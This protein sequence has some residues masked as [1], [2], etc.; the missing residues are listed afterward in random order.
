VPVGLVAWV[1]AMVFH[2][3][4]VPDVIG[5]L[6]GLATLTAAS[7]ALV[8]RGLVD[9]VDRWSRGRVAN[10]LPG[11][12]S[13]PSVLVLVFTTL[14]RAAAILS[15]PHTQWAWVFI[16]TAVVGR[17]AAIFLQG[18]GDPIA[19]D[20]SAR[21][22]VAVPAPAWL[23]AAISGAVVVL[24]VVALGKIGIVAMALAAVAVFAVGLATQRRD[25][26][27]SPGVVATAA[28]IGELLVLL[29]ATIH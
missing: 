16:A 15:V 23:T 27:L 12:M 18:L 11:G 7:A 1:A 5:A 10:A 21:S 13:V 9:S 4:G 29:V 3:A 22:L 20:E 2:A 17:W 8:E 19:H 14:V 25:G 24:A 28:A 6:V 26:G